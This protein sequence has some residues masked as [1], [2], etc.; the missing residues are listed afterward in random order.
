MQPTPEE[1]PSRLPLDDQDR[2]Y[3]AECRPPRL[4]SG[5]GCAGAGIR[6]LT[7]TEDYYF[8]FFW[9]AHLARAAFLALALLSSGLSLAARL[10]P[11]FE[12]SIFP[13]ATLRE[14]SFW[15]FSAYFMP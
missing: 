15:T 12:P 11:P 10:F 13:N 3:K 7:R 1:L 6:E 2:R 5:S 9:L 14:G 8:S 4:G